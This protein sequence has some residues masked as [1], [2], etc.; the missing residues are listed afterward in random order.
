M[1]IHPNQQRGVALLTALLIVTLATMIAVSILSRNH[2]E[3]RRTSNILS[4]NQAWLYALGAESWAVSILQRDKNAYDYMG[5]TWAFQLPQ[6]PVP[7]GELGGTLEDLQGRFNL[8]NLQTINKKVN[9]KSLKH[10]QRLLK[11][12]DLPTSIADE[13]IDWIDTDSY[14]RPSGAEDLEYLLQNPPYRSANQLFHSPSELRL[15][16][17]VDDAVYQ[18]LLPHITALPEITSINVNTTTLPVLNSLI[19]EL[20]EDEVKKLLLVGKQKGFKTMGQLRQRPELKDLEFD[21][22]QLGV[23]SHYFLLK[24]HA[25]MN[26]VDIH[27]NSV[28]RRHKQQGMHVLLHSQ[29]GFW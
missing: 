25:R 27:L 26:S 10:F 11:F 18:T 22:T 23:I 13:V 15:L 21:Q 4:R 20:S 12:L 2:L 1:K 3:I 6:T 14:N 5:E 16:A 9:E 29:G 8:N 19:P 24:A 7:G 17:S 28:I